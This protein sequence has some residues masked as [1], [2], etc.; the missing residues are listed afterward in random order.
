MKIKLMCISEPVP[1]FF[2]YLFDVEEVLG[3]KGDAGAGHRNIL[4]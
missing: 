4:I 1:V 3:I 2:L